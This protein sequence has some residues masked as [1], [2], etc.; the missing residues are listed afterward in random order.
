VRR[1][2][3][4]AL[5][6]LLSASWAAAQ[7]YPALDALHDDRRL[8]E[9]FSALTKLYDKADPQAAVVY[10]LIRCIQETAVQMPKEKKGEKLAKFDEAINFGKPL[11]EAAKGSARDR[12]E[13]YY[14]YG[15]AMGQKGQTMGVLNALF[16]TGDMRAN[17]DKALVI[18]PTFGDP[19]YL[20]AKVD[21]AVPSMA[22]G[23]KTRMGQ[24]FAKA[25]ELAPDNVWYLSDFA[26]A[27]KTRNKNAAFN[28][29]GT[30][31]VPSGKSD[32]EYATVLAKRARDAFAAL[33][34]PTLDQKEKMD[35]LKAAGL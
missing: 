16:M 33:A 7:D 9:E 11:L 20:K 34:K 22:G 29:D 27:L 24:L 4:I 8:A 3:A 5:A 18:D 2:L 35:E 32:M 21:D 31:G 28:K 12:A 19:Y 17:C 6:A 30:K 25:L 13:V 10:R 26:M 1:H 14:W 15:V 23:D